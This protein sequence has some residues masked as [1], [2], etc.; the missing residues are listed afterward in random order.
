MFVRSGVLPFGHSLRLSSYM[1]KNMLS[2][3]AA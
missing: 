2:L 1:Y 3:Q